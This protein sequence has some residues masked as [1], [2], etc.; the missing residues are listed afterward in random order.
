M[1][2]EGVATKSDMKNAGGVQ[3]NIIREI[4]KR[5]ARVEMSSA[6]QL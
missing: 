3:L 5:V 1:K 6:T 4:E 2:T